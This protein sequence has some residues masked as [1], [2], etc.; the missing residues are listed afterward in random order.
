MTEETIIYEKEDSDSDDELFDLSKPHISRDEIKKIL[1]TGLPPGTSM[2]PKNL[3]YYRRALVHKSL[4]KNVRKNLYKNQVVQDYML[5][6]NERIEYLGDAVFGLVVANLL[7]DKYPDKDE[8]FLTRMR[9]KIVRSSHCAKFAKI[10]ELDKYVLT[11]NKVVRIRNSS[12]NISNDRVLEDAFES[13]VGAIY[14]D[15]GFKHAEA[16]ILRLIKDE[17]DF[18]SLLV[19]DNYKDI[20]MRYTQANDYELPIY[21]TI[22]MDGPPHSRKFIISVSL[23]KNGSDITKEFGLGEGSSKKAAEQKAA[24]SSMCSCKDKSCIKIHMKDLHGII[25]RDYE[26]K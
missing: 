4:Q 26:K 22:K 5:E 17:V 19:D 15:L 8:G 1:S 25:N 9:T 14:K 21:E 11:G 6:S 2:R 24:Q 10:L 3:D 18:T 13:F 12:G 20:L 7:Y 23:K 16:F